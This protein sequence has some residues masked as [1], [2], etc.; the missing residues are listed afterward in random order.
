LKG[1]RK[2]MQK[3]IPKGSNVSKDTC[4]QNPST[5]TLPVD[6]EIA[7]GMKMEIARSH[8]FYICII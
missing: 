3:P 8:A 6:K 4:F 2:P 1:K 7:D 5:A